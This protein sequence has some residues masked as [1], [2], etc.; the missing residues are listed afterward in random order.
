[1]T[2]TSGRRG[3]FEAIYQQYVVPRRNFD[4]LSQAEREFEKAECPVFVVPR[5][6]TV[7]F[8]VA[9]PIV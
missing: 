7:R 9:I 4:G 8:P 1:M 6:V 3:T 5:G 2:S